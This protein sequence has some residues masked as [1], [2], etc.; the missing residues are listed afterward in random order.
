M[1]DNRLLNLYV[2]LFLILVGFPAYC[3]SDFDVYLKKY[4]KENGVFISKKEKIDVFIDKEGLPYFE[5]TVYEEK[6]Y[7]NENF[8]YFMDESIHYSSFTE[9][10]NLKPEVHIPAE[11]GYKKK[12]ITDITDEDEHESGIFHD[13]NKSKVFYY[14]GLVK[15]GKTL[16]TY[17]EKI[18]NPY[19]F[20]SG[21]FASYFPV[22]HVE[23]IITAPSDM[24]ILCN[25]FGDEKDKV[26]YSKVVKGKNTIHTWSAR[27]LKK[28]EYNEGGVPV[29]TFATHA[30]FRVGNYKAGKEDKYL[31]RSVDDLYEYYYKLVKDV[32]NQP[33]EVLQN[34]SDSITNGR[35]SND[36][37][38]KAIYY[39]VQNNIKYVA[40]E[41]GMGGF[42]PR[43][44]GL[45]C[46]RRYGDCKDMSSLLYKLLNCAGL[47]AYYTWIGTRDIPYKYEEVPCLSVDNHMIC[48]YM[49]E[50]GPVFLDA[51][52]NENPFNWPTSF[53]Q[54]KEALVGVGEKEFKLL[55]V[56]ILS[57]ETNHTIDSVF[58]D[59]K[60][61]KVHGNGIIQYNGYSS[62]RLRSAI[63]NM[64]NSQKKEF[65]SSSFKKGNNKS[66]CGVD[67]LSG[68]GNKELPLEVFYFF[69]IDDYTKTNEDELYFNPFLKKYWKSEQINTETIKIALENQYGMMVTSYVQIQIPEGYKVQ[70]LPKNMEYNYEKFG[71]ETTIVQNAKSVEVTYQFFQDGLTIEKNEFEEW[72]TFIKKLNQ[73]YSELIIFKKV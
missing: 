22:E 11:K 69:D 26:V 20:G 33:N 51:T 9:I 64:D 24:E 21:Y 72:N 58:V 6:I 45:V 61:G 54:G 7:L 49:S 1:K 4:P 48:T 3:Q 41:D 40:F 27:N 68:L 53:I 35:E 10:S 5:S 19:F 62:F 56:P 37:K 63:Q 36:D 15:G 25:L 13:D 34:L 29:S 23:Y 39:W 71:F 2:T 50:N 67:S 73:A 14:S 44:A 57:K 52:S 18:N 30:I 31:L 28:L 38:A 43:E 70:Y 16:L 66:T 55:Q 42:V 17:D 60:E 46:N 32:N 47:P 12:V 59:L 65:Y 8:K